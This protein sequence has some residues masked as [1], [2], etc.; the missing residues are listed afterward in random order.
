MIPSLVNSPTIY[1]PDNAI[2]F[3]FWVKPDTCFDGEAIFTKSAPNDDLD[4]NIL[5]EVRPNCNLAIDFYVAS[6]GGWYP[7]FHNDTGINLSTTDWNHVVITYNGVDYLKAYLNGVLAYDYA[8]VSFTD[9]SNAGIVLGGQSTTEYYEYGEQMILDGSIDDFMVFSRELTETEAGDLFNNISS[10]PTD[11]LLYLSFN[12][13]GDTSYTPIEGTDFPGVNDDVTIN[14]GTVVLSGDQSV[15]N[16]TLATGGTLDLN[17]YTL[18]VAGDWNNTGGALTTNG[19]TINLV[20]TTTQKILGENTF[21][22]LTKNA[23]ASSTL[24]F[25]SS[26]TTTITGTL[27]LNG[28]SGNILSIAPYGT[29]ATYSFVSSFGYTGSGDGEFLY[30]GGIIMDSSNNIYVA[31]APNYR[32]QKFDSSGNYLSQFGSYGTGDG[33]FAYPWGLAFDSSGNIYVVDSDNHRIEKF[34]SDGN[35]L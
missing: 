6:N 26:A 32:V 17:G 14:S 3:S 15:H 12:E 20:S 29:A 21:E 8:G 13:P 11:Y 16:L 28:S 18:N 33:Q 24:L 2:S 30:P 34:D 23:T 35:Y 1:G 10:A 22:N 4:G 19:G 9:I 7:G 5:V 25:D 31:D 27:E